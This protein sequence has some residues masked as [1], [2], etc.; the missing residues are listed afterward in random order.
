MSQKTDGITREHK[1]WKLSSSSLRAVRILVEEW[2]KLGAELMMIRCCW[3]T[4]HPSPLYLVLFAETKTHEAEFIASNDYLSSKFCTNK[5]FPKNPLRSFLT[6]EIF[7]YKQHLW[8]PYNHPA[9]NAAAWK[10]DPSGPSTIKNPKIIQALIL[11]FSG[12]RTAFS[13][14]KIM[15]FVCTDLFLLKTD[16]R[17]HFLHIHAQTQ[18]QKVLTNFGL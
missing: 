12:Y 2:N 6:P 8:D 1:I 5:L 18:E 11:S 17:T 9:G 14:Y 15:S 4:T 10:R 16:P 3:W 7:L 13:P